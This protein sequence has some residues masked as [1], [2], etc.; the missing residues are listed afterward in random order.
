MVQTKEE[1]RQKKKEYHKKWAKEHKKELKEYGKEYNNTHKREEKEYNKNYR[2]IHKEELSENKKIY[3][4]ENKEYFKEYLK[5]YRLNNKEK[6]KE[7]QKEYCRQEKIEAFN[8]LGGCK[9]IICGESKIEFLTIDHIDNS[10]ALDKKEGL[11]GRKLYQ[12][13]LKNTYPKDRLSNL[14]VLCYNH[15]CSRTR[16]YLIIPEKEKTYDQKYQT[17]LWQEAYKFFGPCKSCGQKELIF[18]CISHIHNNGSEMRKNGEKT[19]TKLLQ[20]FRKLGWPESL[21]E[22]Y[23]LECFSC[24]CSRKSI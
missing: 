14:R 9:C 3:R 13:I 7:Y 10:G 23:C 12:S 20:K 19:G 22:D 6:A 4:S 11:F 18:L 5:I 16:T 1:K 8:I 15:N 2:E 24:N 17:K 21:K